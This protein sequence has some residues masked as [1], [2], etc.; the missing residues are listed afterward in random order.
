[1]RSSRNA[2]RRVRPVGWCGVP[3]SVSDT[4]QSIARAL[5]SCRTIVAQLLMRFVLTVQFR[6]MDAEA[7]RAAKKW[8]GT[9]K[10]AGN[11]CDE[12]ARQAVIPCELP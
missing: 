11:G 8:T 7:I 6:R 1:M 2:R 4:K 3:V 5:S 9:R 10:L 12:E